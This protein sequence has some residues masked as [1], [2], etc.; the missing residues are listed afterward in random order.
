MSVTAKMNVMVDANVSLNA[1]AMVNTNELTLAAMRGAGVR[2][3]WLLMLCL[4]AAVVTGVGCGD[5]DD[6]TGNDSG[7]TSSPTASD[8]DDDTSSGDDDDT[9]DGETGDDDDVDATDGET[10][11][12]TGD[13]TGGETG[14]ETDGETGDTL[15]NN[16]TEY[17]DVFVGTGGVGFGVGTLNPGPAVPFSMAKPGPDSGI[18]GVQASFVHC[19]GYAYGDREIWGFSHSRFNGMGVSDY[20]ALQ[21][22]PT[23]GMETKKTRVAGTRQK[24]RK[25]TEEASPGYY[26]VTLEDTG[27]RAEL[28][29]TKW[30]GLHRYTWPSADDDAVVVLNLHYLHGGQNRATGLTLDYD[31]ETLTATG[32]LTV[33]GDYSDRQGGIPTYFAV[34]FNKAPKSFGTWDAEGAIAEPSNTAAGE[35]IGG[36]A[37]FELAEG[38]LAVELFAAIS[39]TS[40]EG[41]LTNL[42]ASLTDGEIDFEATR[43]AADAAWE[44]ELAKIRVKGGS[45]EAK[46]RFYTAMYHTMFAPQ[47]YTDADGDYIGFDDKVH[48]AGEQEYY[49]DF[50]MWDTYRTLHPLFNFIQRDRTADM[51]QSLVRMYEQGGDVPKWPIGRGY[52]GGMIG[53]PADIVLGDTYLKGIRNWDFEKGFE[54][55]KLHATEPRS[56]DG[57]E[58]YA[59]YRD[60]GY[61]SVE[62]AGASV[63]A[64]AEA[65]HAD[66]SLAAWAAAMGNDEDAEF[67]AARTTNYRNH[68]EPT[69]KFLIGRRDDGSF[70]TEEFNE[71][72]WKDYYSEG[73]A[74]QYLWFVPW[75]PEGLIDL[76]GGAA[77]YLEKLD[78]YFE[79]SVEH[80]ETNTL[81][82]LGPYPYY[83]HSNEPA[84]NGTF[85]YIDAG[86]P[87]LAQKWAR[88]A[89]ETNYG[90]GPDG[91][92]GNDD[93]GTMSAWYIFVSAGLYPVPGSQKFWVV[94]PQFEELEIFMGDKETS[95]RKLTIFAPGAGA[96]NVY[97]AGVTVN[98]KALERAALTWEEIQ[99]GGEIRF[100]LSAT[101]TAWGKF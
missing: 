69:L 83:W 93:G 18:N 50:S 64:T 24:Y 57:R 85:M 86:R 100:T 29:A 71:T 60:R 12:E 96:E 37:R 90:D 65:C 1:N 4:C 41:A 46:R 98:G 101:P 67:F 16:L 3:R 63:S 97:V 43:D 19:S 75:D 51:A 79:K 49:S 62:A 34:R 28:T 99:D 92:P 61:V 73:N 38:E 20:G 44:V 11:D 70:V 30:G 7:E 77:A 32:T 40:I 23:T 81:G 22:T 80:L 66:A 88:W 56:N 2:S 94:S 91:L 48:A 76:F 26:A 42:E 21:I 27:V 53:T 59:A 8:D 31:A 47:S 52:T 15:E 95:D 68:W 55:C 58:G 10:A 13:E 45:D 84:L 14:G 17:V 54:G 33:N 9:S 78:A 6:D 72:V 35:G 36:F 39:Y 25:S 74:W 87:D 82:R 89:L 5:D